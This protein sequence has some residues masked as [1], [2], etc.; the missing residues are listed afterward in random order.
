MKTVNLPA[1]IAIMQDAI[2]ALADPQSR[3]FNGTYC[4][5]PALYDQLLDSIDGAQGRGHHGAFRS[6]PLIWVDAVDLLN[7]IDGVVLDWTPD[8]KGTTIDRLHALQDAENWTPDTVGTVR[9]I[10]SKCDG[11]CRTITSMLDPALSKTISAPCPACE[12][13]H[14]YRNDT[15]GESVRSPALAI[16]PTGCICRACGYTWPPE[17]FEMLEHILSHPL[18]ARINTVRCA[19]TLT[20]MIRVPTVFLSGS[21]QLR[22]KAKR[23]AA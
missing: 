18:F 6:M 12:R 10:T 15:A 22:A 11:W 4:E 2:W 19:G 23:V 14:V 7:E 8:A 13:T 21:G 1:E 16:G 3:R 5:A 17:R 20:A 9:K